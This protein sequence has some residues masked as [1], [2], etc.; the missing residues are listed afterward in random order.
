MISA[1]S[2]D[3][4]KGTLSKLHA[5]LPLC[6]S[7]QVANHKLLLSADRKARAA[8]VLSL[9]SGAYNAPA[10]ASALGAGVPAVAGALTGVASAPGSSTAP[11]PNSIVAAG[12]EG[13]VAKK[14]GN[15]AGFGV[16]HQGFVCLE[17]GSTEGS[18][19]WLMEMKQVGAGQ[20]CTPALCSTAIH[21][22][23][24]VRVVR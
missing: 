18:G 5:T 7:S 19:H 4:F 17:S 16:A 6:R 9:A 8:A 10:G 20:A 3:G 12:P 24:A 21:D 14:V 2:A 1:P 23:Q 22:R 13:E 15:K 11:V